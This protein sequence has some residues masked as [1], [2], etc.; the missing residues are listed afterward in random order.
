MKQKVWKVKSPYIENSSQL[1]VRLG[2]SPLVAQL[3]INRGI[4]TEVAARAYLY[5]TFANLHD[6]FQMPNMEKAVDRIHA[7]IMR[8]EQIWVYGDYDTDGTTSAALL[9]NTFRNLDVPAN[10]YIP[11]RFEEGYGLNKTAIRTIRE[12]GGDLLITVDC[13]ITSIAE[14]EL[15]NEIGLDVIITDHH[16]P[17]PDASPPAHAI[18]S[19]K[20]PGSEY[21]FDGL[22][23][24]GLAFKLAHGLIGGDE[25][26]P[27][28]ISQLD[29]VTLGTVVDIATLTGENRILTKLGLA[30]INM[31]KR[32]GIRAL[33]DVANHEVSKPIVGHT[34]SFVLGPRVNAAG[35]MDTAKK[36]VELL[37]TESYEEAMQIAQELDANNRTRKEVENRIQGEAIDTIEKNIDLNKTKGL[38][39]A[40]K[41][42]H[43]GVIGIVA[44]RILERYYRPVFLLAID[45][46]E[47]H[48][49]GRCI[50]EMNLADSLDACTDLLVKH[51]GHQAAAGLTIK[52]ENI[53][54]FKEHFNQYACEHL[55]DEDLT[56]KLNL[57]LE[58]QPPYLTLE[59]VEELDELLEPFGQ[60]NPAPRLVMRELLLQRPPRLMGKENEHLKLFV[61]DGRHTMEAVGWRMADY[62]VVLKNRNLRL[63][64]AF[65][66]E[67]NE[68]N[69]TRRLQLRIKDL[70]IRTE[71]RR[72]QPAVFP[73]VEA[74][75]P[76][77]IVDRRHTNKQNY[78]LKLLERGQPSVLYVR[79]AKAIDQLL[80]LLGSEKNWVLGRCD[81]T[82]SDT[83]KQDM[84]EKLAS[85]EI[86]TIVSSCRLTDLSAVTHLVFCH[87]VPQPLTFFNQCRPA[88]KFPETTYIHL[89]YNSKDVEWLHRLLSLQYP[90]KELLRNLYKSLQSSCRNNDHRI[91]LEEFIVD[92]Q[93]ASIS[94]LAIP[95]GL[96]IFE[97]LQFLRRHSRAS[98]PEIELLTPST[99]KRELHESET[100]LHGEQIKQ[101]SQLFSEFLLRQSLQKIW[102]RISYECRVSG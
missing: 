24:V 49:S 36:V 73:A 62:F 15:A 83:E 70:H 85:G 14:V 3:L 75:S 99:Q 69:N 88:F 45:G 51:G 22:A 81:D 55:S 80:A 20:M 5:P 23:G 59:T 58:I 95:N 53:P 89:I 10:F 2:I 6:P 67:I 65:A 12:S 1:S 100:Y 90:D 101:T 54:K 64:L 63:D 94:A 76:V 39:V 82:T 52:T 38:V 26:T 97:E 17:R 79:D 21:P 8:G 91:K 31:R 60:D 33:C 34:L 28:L 41:D 93:A 18:I 86:L 61:T 84:V 42:W 47:A 37:T 19:P 98:H 4:E 16:Q 56:P 32:P 7:A 35:R 92:A 48:G 25:L 96:T 9:L 78:L 43:Q 29:L 46:D 71:D 27:F 72:S 66:P 68:W 57:D 40:R 74:E 50:A 87:P 77:K 102:E 13:G 30:E 44:S 11:N